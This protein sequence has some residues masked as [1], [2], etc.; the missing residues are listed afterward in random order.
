MAGSVEMNQETPLELWKRFTYVDNLP[1]DIGPFRKLLEGYS[2]IP[3]EE[4]DGL[5]LR[6]VGNGSVLYS[7]WK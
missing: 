5:L 2:N 1:E 4:V 7:R 3:P 6:T